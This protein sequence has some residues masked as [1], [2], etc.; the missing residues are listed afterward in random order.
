MEI[1]YEELIKLINNHKIA[2]VKFS[3]DGYPHYKNCKIIV[4]KEKPKSRMFYLIEVILTKD[5]SEFV[6]FFDDFNE[7]Y[8]LFNFKRKGKYTLK[9]I[10]NWVKIHSIEFLE[11]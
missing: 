1:K 6:S 4:I 11:E 7:E 9:Q 2:E 3:I 8:K 10:W 5:M